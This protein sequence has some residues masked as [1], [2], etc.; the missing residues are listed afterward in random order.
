MLSCGGWSSQPLASE[1]G[2]VFLNLLKNKNNPKTQVALSLFTKWTKRASDGK[3]EVSLQVSGLESPMLHSDPQRISTLLSASLSGLPF[4]CNIP[5]SFQIS[6]KLKAGY[7]LNVLV[8]LI[9][10]D[11]IN[12]LQQWLL[13]IE[14][15]HH[16]QKIILNIVRLKTLLLVYCNLAPSFDISSS[17]Q[18]IW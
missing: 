15:P 6:V 1:N 7:W 14:N 4:A 9:H 16:I 12:L 2:V 13:R 17:M 18:Q 5:R 11:A 10:Q 3:R 8:C